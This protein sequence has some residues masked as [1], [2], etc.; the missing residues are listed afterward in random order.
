MILYSIPP[1]PPPRQFRNLCLKCLL[2]SSINFFHDQYYFC[3]CFCYIFASCKSAPLYG[4]QQRVFN[5]YYYHEA[6]AVSIVS[7]L[8]FINL[9]LF[10]RSL[11]NLFCPLIHF[12]HSLLHS[13]QETA[14][15]DF[16]SNSK[17]IPTQGQVQT[18]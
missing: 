4:G 17:E 9:L 3:T 15:S 2:N 11:Q 1:P 8:F 14:Y 18:R 12:L 13:G 5:D 6:T 16:S 7:L 10:F